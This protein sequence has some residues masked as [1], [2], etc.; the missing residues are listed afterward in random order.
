MHVMKYLHALFRVG[1]LDCPSATVFS[2]TVL[3]YRWLVERGGV[4]VHPSFKQDKSIGIA[5]SNV[6][7]PNVEKLTSEKL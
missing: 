2:S 3:R 1:D 6:I 7:D 5:R 4:L